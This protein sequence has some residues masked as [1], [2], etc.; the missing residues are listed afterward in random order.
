MSEVVISQLNTKNN[1]QETPIK[2]STQ[3]FT[4]SSA[5][6]KA[7]EK[8]MKSYVTALSKAGA[9]NCSIKTATEALLTGREIEKKPIKVKAKKAKKAKKP[10][11][12]E[13][14]R[15]AK[16]EAAA[17][18]KAELKAKKEAEKAELKA[19]KEVEKA[20]LKAKKE[21]EKEMAKAAALIFKAEERAAKKEAAA[22]LKADKKA[23]L[24]EKKALKEA[25][26]LKIKEDKALSAI[27]KV[28]AAAEAKEAA[29]TL[30][31][32]KKVQMPFLKAN[33]DESICDAIVKNGGL[34]TQC[35]KKCSGD[36]TSFCTKCL[37]DA[38]GSSNG[39]PKHGLVKNRIIGGFKEGSAPAGFEKSTG[40][41]NFA[42]YLVKKKIS[43]DDAQAYAV[44]S[45][46]NIDDFPEEYL[47]LA[48][49]KKR[50]RKANTAA[51]S[52]S[53]DE[54]T[55][56]K[57]GRPAKKARA[58]TP[59]NELLSQMLENSDSD[60]E[61]GESDGV[62]ATKFEH[63]SMPGFDMGI[64]S[65]FNIYNTENNELIGKYDV[66]NDVI[67]F[68]GSDD[69]DSELSEEDISYIDD[70]EDM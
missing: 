14:E 54:E 65:E 62:E 44:A 8:E 70:D 4:P 20:E 13:Q 2:M 48:P 29:K 30:K 59:T 23:A 21:A 57:R 69:D 15:A 67:N 68:V 50:G 58:V 32:I 66:A 38:E 46:L 49:K 52:D 53:D 33:E 41:V 36:E 60:H 51:V 6:L 18:I 9:L 3:S 28:Q 19:K 64:D 12:S 40:Y 35:I 16:K 17:E 61:E 10:K 34:Y 11:M 25:T 63:A 39:Q 5:F 37:K 7:V 45:G 47:K 24:A 56:K 1:T 43:M 27:L 31:S 55:K 26:K 22:K 42:N